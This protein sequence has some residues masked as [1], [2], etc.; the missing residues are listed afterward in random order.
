MRSLVAGVT[1]LLSTVCLAGPAHADHPPCTI[2][3]TPGDDVLVGTA[4]DDVICGLAGRDRLAGGDGRDVLVGGD[5]GD[6]LQGGDGDDVLGGGVGPDVLDGQ[7]GADV[8]DGG[9]GVDEVSYAG[10]AAAVTVTVGAGADDGATGEG[11]DVGGTV[12]RVRGGRGD[13]RLSGGGGN[14]QLLGGDGRD[15]LR[16]AGGRD[17]LDGGE[18]D[19]SLDGGEPGRG[20][21]DTLACGPGTDTYVPDPVD[22]LTACET[23][24]VTTT[25]AI[26]IAAGRSHTCALR[27][28]STVVCW[29]KAGSGA[30]GDGTAAGTRTL[31]GPSVV[32][33]SNVTAI[34]AGDQFTCALRAGG[35]VS[36]W[37]RNDEG[38]LGDA[39]TVARKEPVDVHGMTDAVAITAGEKHACALHLDGRVSCWGQHQ[40]G[41]LGDSDG[42]TDPRFGSAYPRSTTPV[43][44]DGLTD[45]SEVHAGSYFTCARRASGLVVCW[46]GG[47]PGLDAGPGFTA[48]VYRSVVQDATAFDAGS[49]HVRAERTSGAVVC[50]GPNESGELGGGFT[51][52]FVDG[53]YQTNT[54]QGITVAGLSGVSVLALA[55]GY[56]C[57]R[58][59]D[60]TAACWGLAGLLGDGTDDGRLAPTAVVDLADAETLAAGASHV[61]ALRTTG[62]ISCWGRNG[63]GQLGDGTTEPRNA[64]TPVIGFS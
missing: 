33:L 8:F 30:L 34:A 4:G 21:R 52:P 37:G 3:G 54:E 15:D 43:S 13:D 56:S 22:I 38:Q 60:S 58:R 2:T 32:G 61:C 19:D 42:W 53:M 27:A 24:R 14:D 39:T 40:V 18:G 28:D 5:G 51:S 16:G 10:R 41:Q 55:E 25:P 46:G 49:H 23:P 6:R 9:D 35:A 62:A 36:C 45:A 59:E 47:G 11:D 31:P 63:Y 64:P 48:D 7:A 29:G 20:E 57:V 26:A 44:V 17:Q 1:L 50:W 12:E